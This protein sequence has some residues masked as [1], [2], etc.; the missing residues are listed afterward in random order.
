LISLKKNFLA[1]QLDYEDLLSSYELWCRT[2]CY[3]FLKFLTESYIPKN[4]SSVFIVNFS[5]LL[6]DY[7]GSHRFL[8]RLKFRDESYPQ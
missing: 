1:M 4:E 7:K 3:I 6:Q 8:Y 5:K 2:I